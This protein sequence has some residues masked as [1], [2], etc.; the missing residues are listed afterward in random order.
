MFT[1]IHDQAIGH[2][3]SIEA[4][5]TAQLMSHVFKANFMANL[6]EKALE[7]YIK[8]RTVRM[9]SKHFFFF[10]ITGESTENVGLV[11]WG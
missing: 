3:I 8:L 9:M 1:A 5:I 10:N 2:P 6:K 11:C 4:V 7:S